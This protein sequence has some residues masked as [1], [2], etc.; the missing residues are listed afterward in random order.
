MRVKPNIWIGIGIFL[1]YVV[2]IVGIGLAL[3]TNYLTIAQD[4]GT[5]LRG[6]IIP[7]GVGAVVL[8]IIVSLLGWWRPVIREERTWHPTW[9][10]IVVLVLFGLFVIGNLVGT[11]WSKTNV[12]YVAVLLLGV[13]LVGF[14]EETVNRGILLTVFRS[15]LP[16]AGA[17]ILS[18]AFFGLM[19]SAN[20]ALGQPLAPTIQQVAITAL[21]GLGFYSVRLLTGSLIWA[22]ALHAVYDFSTFMVGTTGGTALGG[23]VSYPLFLAIPVAAIVVWVR[24]RRGKETGQPEPVA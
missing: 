6:V 21:F 18:S 20:L 16:E 15:K 5:L 10:L 2:I 12:T 22:M 9:L 19:H 7:V 1:L 24:S 23:V 14:A 3:G 13:L 11:D 4:E 17:A 8:A